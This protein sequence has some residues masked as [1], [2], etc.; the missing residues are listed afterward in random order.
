MRDGYIRMSMYS[1]E[2]LRLSKSVCH[3][4]GAFSFYFFTLESVHGVMEHV[5]L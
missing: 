2:G 1:L 3:R 4:K 5:S